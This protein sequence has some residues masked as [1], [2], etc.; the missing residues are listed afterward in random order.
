V[1]DNGVSISFKTRGWTSKWVEQRLG[2]RVFHADGMDLSAMM[3]ASA[4]AAEY[5]RSS[6][7]P[8]TLLVTNLPRRFVHAS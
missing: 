5:V 1:S 7:S 6:R 4:A 2:M 3:S 8:A